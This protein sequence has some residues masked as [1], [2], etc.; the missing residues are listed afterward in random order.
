MSGGHEQLGFRRIAIL[1]H[2][3]HSL[4]SSSTQQ[5]YYVAGVAH[6]QWSFHQLDVLRCLLAAP[7]VVSCT[8]HKPFANQNLAPRAPAQW[9][10]Y[11]VHLDCGS[12]VRCG[13][14]PFMSAREQRLVDVQR[15]LL[16]QICRCV[17]FLIKQ[18]EIG[19][20]TNRHMLRR[21][22]AERFLE[23]KHRTNADVRP[24]SQPACHNRH[25]ECSSP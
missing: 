24:T 11:H 5:W 8:H 3:D 1:S 20:L 12:T 15:S 19:E 4:H 14:S 6:T 7:V 2:L 23:H 13:T 18:F 10:L 25:A 16:A 21:A 9:R 22:V 17:P